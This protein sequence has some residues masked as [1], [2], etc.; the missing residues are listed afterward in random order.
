M[1]RVR[2]V[3]LYRKRGAIGYASHW[4]KAFHMHE[5]Y[6]FLGFGKLMPEAQTLSGVRVPERIHGEGAIPTTKDIL[7][8]EIRASDVPSTNRHD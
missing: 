4:S 7:V 3:C 2:T 5:G 8:N 6:E 1:S